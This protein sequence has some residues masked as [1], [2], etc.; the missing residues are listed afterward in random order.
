MGNFFNKFK[1]ISV[2]ICILWT[3]VSLSVGVVLLITKN[4][5]PNKKFSLDSYCYASFKDGVSCKD[6]ISEIFLTYDYALF[7]SLMWG[8]YGI[9]KFS[10]EALIFLPIFLILSLPVWITIFVL[11]KKFLVNRKTINQNVSVG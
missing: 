4:I 2:R 6:P 7:L 9:V 3:I 1:T 5:Y 8:G 10:I 11:I